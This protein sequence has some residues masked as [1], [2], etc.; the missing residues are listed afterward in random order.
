MG[1]RTQGGSLN[2]SNQFQLLEGQKE[3]GT[4]HMAATTQGQKAEQNQQDNQNKFSTKKWV[5]EKF[6]QEGGSTEICIKRKGM[7][8]M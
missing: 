6:G 5:E 4:P 7:G 2:T 8:L 3:D 1:R